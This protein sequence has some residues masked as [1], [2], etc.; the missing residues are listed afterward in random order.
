MTACNSNLTWFQLVLLK[1]LPLYFSGLC[2]KLL[3]QLLQAVDH[4]QL[5]T[6]F[7]SMPNLINTD[8]NPNSQ[9]SGHQDFSQ[10]DHWNTQQWIHV[11]KWS[12]QFLVE[13]YR[14]NLLVILFFCSSIGPFFAINESHKDKLT[15]CF[16]QWCFLYWGDE[17]LNLR[18]PKNLTW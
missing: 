5:S 2:E 14:V 18:L 16:S 12:T 1:V 7:S 17:L 11:L 6:S 4:L 13:N 10:V 3:P 15:F 8:T 9:I